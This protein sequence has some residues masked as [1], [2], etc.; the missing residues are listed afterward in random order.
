[1]VEAEVAGTLA[2][3][4][5]KPRRSNPFQREDLDAWT[6]WELGWSNEDYS[7]RLRAVA[8]QALTIVPMLI[9]RCRT[10]SATE[11]ERALL[12]TLS[13]YHLSSQRRDS[14]EAP[15]EAL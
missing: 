3:K 12:K 15:A 6:N 9:E 8:E 2:R 10:G 13:E 14:L 5:N 7:D 11:E 4:A 1:L